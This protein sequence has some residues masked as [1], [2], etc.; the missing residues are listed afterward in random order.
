LKAASWILTGLF[1]LTLVWSLSQ[2]PS[3]GDPTAPLSVHISSRYA[4]QSVMETGFTHPLPAVLG[5]YRSFDMILLSLLSL[6]ACLVRWGS[7]REQESKLPP[8]R[9]LFFVLSVLGSMILMGLGF[10]TLFKGCRFLDYECWVRFAPPSMAR[11]LGAEWS[12]GL[13]AFVFLLSFFVRS[14]GKS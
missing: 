9:R 5:D 8:L 2:M 1:A 6:G 14:K 12:L 11:V 4:S 7:A 10:Y 13:T 3:P